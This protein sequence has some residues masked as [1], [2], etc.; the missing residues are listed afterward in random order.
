MRPHQTQ[1]VLHSKRSHQENEMTTYGMK[2]KLQITYF[3]SAS[4]PGIYK[5]RMQLSSRRN[6]TTQIIKWARKNKFFENF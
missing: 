5:R 1:N 2:K 4:Y 6:Q 3:I